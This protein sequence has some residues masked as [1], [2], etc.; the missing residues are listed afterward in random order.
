MRPN[1]LNNG[2]RKGLNAV[3]DTTAL[4]CPAD[5]MWAFQVYTPLNVVDGRKG[6]DITSARIKY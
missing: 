1:V 2:R 5:M 6:A 3:S 4:G